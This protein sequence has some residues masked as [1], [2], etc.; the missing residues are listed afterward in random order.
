MKEEI[1]KPEQTYDS[2][3]KEMISVGLL[4]R[5]YALIPYK[6]CIDEMQILELY[7]TTCYNK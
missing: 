7:L 4:P 5:N 6:R 1:D 2:L 3:M